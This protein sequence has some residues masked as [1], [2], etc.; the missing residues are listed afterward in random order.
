MKTTKFLFQSA[1]SIAILLLISGCNKTG[2]DTSSLY[3]PTSANVTA[4]ATLQELQQGRVL[5]INNCGQCHSL[6][7]PDSYTPTQ[8]RS[9][10]PAMTPRTNLS[11]PE[12]QLV[13]KYVCKGN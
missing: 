8:W 9:I 1:F 12:V 2:T 3:T 13:T 4:T 7:S 6:A 5:F 11:A 10:L